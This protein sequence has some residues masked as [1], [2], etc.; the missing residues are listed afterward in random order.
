VYL[1]WCFVGSWKVKV[2]EYIVF[3]GVWLVIYT[4]RWKG[5]PQSWP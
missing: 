3:F 5:W 2:K 4:W 1:F